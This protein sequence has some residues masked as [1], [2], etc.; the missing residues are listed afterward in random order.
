MIEDFK[1]LSKACAACRGRGVLPASAGGAKCP[2]CD[3]GW[4]KGSGHP[5][6]PPED[7]PE[8]A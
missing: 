5:E 4:V 1:P 7:A 6:L 8:D 2:H 3:N